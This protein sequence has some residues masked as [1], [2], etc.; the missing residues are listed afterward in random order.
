MV[1]RFWKYMKNTYL[2]HLLAPTFIAQNPKNKKQIWCGLISVYF[3]CSSSVYT[4][5]DHDLFRTLCEWISVDI[6]II[7]Q[8]CLRSSE[9]KKIIYLGFVP[10]EGNWAKRFIFFKH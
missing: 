9:L 7:G 4:A 3:D 6:K 2:N 1:S 10:S 5:H 8:V